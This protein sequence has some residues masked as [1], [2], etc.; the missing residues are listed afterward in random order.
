MENIL[1][2]I[3][4]KEYSKKSLILKKQKDYIY[5]IY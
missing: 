5:K 1:G 4:L 3:S 2:E